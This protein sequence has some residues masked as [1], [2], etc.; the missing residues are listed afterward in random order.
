MTCLTLA[1]AWGCGNAGLFSL[2]V[3]AHGAAGEAQSWAAVITVGWVSA[4]LSLP[5]LVFLGGIVLK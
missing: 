1:A 4:A 5:L 3:L 2:L